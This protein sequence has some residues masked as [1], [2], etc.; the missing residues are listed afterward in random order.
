MR[1]ASVCLLSFCLFYYD[2]G[3]FRKALIRIDLVEMRNVRT[4]LDPLIICSPFPTFYS[5]SSHLIWDLEC[6]RS[7]SLTVFCITQIFHSHVKLSLNWNRGSNSL[8]CEEKKERKQGLPF[9]C[10]RPK[11]LSTTR[12]PFNLA[13]W[14]IR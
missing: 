7:P 11:N 2:N 8:R 3:P 4:I 9:G 13:V 1:S 14:Q 12:P 10:V 5:I 6:C